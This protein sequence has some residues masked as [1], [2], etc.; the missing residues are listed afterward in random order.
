MLKVF[1]FAL[2]VILL[3]TV[4]FLLQSVNRYKESFR[5][6]SLF[7]DWPIP[8]VEIEKFDERFQPQEQGPSKNTEIF[9]I[10]SHGTRGSVSDFETWIL[11]NFAKNAS[12]IFEFG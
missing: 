6:S 5:Q 10:G 4:F 8:K 7:G 3:V 11:C 1:L 2:N 9:F 12:N